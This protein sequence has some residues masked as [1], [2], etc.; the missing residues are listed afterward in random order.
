M[1]EIEV[2][3]G[4][5]L[6]WLDE[7]AEAKQVEFDLIITDPPYDSLLKWQGVG[8]TARMG[9]GKGKDATKS[10]KFYPVVNKNQMLGILRF[11]DALSKKDSHTYLMCDHEYMPLILTWVRDPANGFGWKYSK[12]LVW[13]KISMGMGYHW[14][15]LH[16]Y[17]IM[18]EK[19]K[20][21]LNDL[22]KGDILR[23][24]RVVGGY[25]TEKPFGLFEELI[26][27]SSQEGD[28]VMDPF[29]GS[30]VTAAV[31]KTHKRNCFTMDIEQRSIDHTTA[32]LAAIP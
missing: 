5:S 23:H 29:C 25:P 1:S 24:K 6:K 9:F 3:L 20:R 28:W 8:T 30:G 15:G 10:T 31:C 7:T 19:G 11:L 26:L 18:L 16:E 21:R 32:R 2:H 22:G 27:N 13:D 4:D 12:S 14:R 17:V